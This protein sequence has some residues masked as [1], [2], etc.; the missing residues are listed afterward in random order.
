MSKKLRIIYA[1]AFGVLLFTEIMIALFV[2]DDFIRPYV[3]DVLVTVLICCLCRTIF[4]KGVL[5]LPIYVFAFAVFVELM[6]YFQ[7]V[8]LLGLENNAFFSTII[9]T[10]FSTVDLIC[11]G[12]GCFVF[13]S[14]E[15][16]AYAVFKHH[17]GS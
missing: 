16:V 15:K 10:T 4:P 14:A 9:G 2:H 6:Q 3:G 11:Y 12:I 1:N 5:A 13:W 17:K 7:I 8:K